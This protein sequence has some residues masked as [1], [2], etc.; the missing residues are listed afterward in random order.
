[1]FSFLNVILMFLL[2]CKGRLGVLVDNG[3]WREM[4]QLKKSNANPW[5]G[6]QE[7]MHGEC[8]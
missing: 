1:M 8:E 2:M 7:E 5:D 4:L 3:L 6:Y